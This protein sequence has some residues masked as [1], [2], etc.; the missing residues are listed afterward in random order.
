MEGGG[1]GVRG[2]GSWLWLGSLKDVSV[3]GFL[4]PTKVCGSD[5]SVNQA[6]TKRW[7]SAE[8]MCPRS[9]HSEKGR[10]V[11]LFGRSERL[12][13]VLT[14]ILSRLLRRGNVLVILDSGLICGIDFC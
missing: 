3:V 7:R 2:Q 14:N 1:G 11:G 13:T 12:L 8:G 5:K 9:F 10:R 6:V 4:T